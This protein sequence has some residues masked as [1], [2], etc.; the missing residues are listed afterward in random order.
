MGN[1]LGNKRFE[2]KVTLDQT[3]DFALSTVPYRLIEGVL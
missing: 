2:I 1:L 3:Q